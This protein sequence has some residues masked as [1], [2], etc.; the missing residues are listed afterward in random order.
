MY[1]SR[2]LST[3][4]DRSSAQIS[5][6]MLMGPR[7]AGKTTFMRQ[8]NASRSF[9]TLDD[10]ELRTLAR[11]DP[12]TFLARFPPPVLIDEFHYAPQLLPYIKM[13]VDERRTRLEPAGGMYWLTGSQ[14]FQMIK[15]VQES[16]AGRAIIFQL[17]GLS[18]KEI[19]GGGDYAGDFLADPA[20]PFETRKGIR[21]IFH[22]I[23]RGD[24]P[25]L[26]ACPTIDRELYYRSYVQTYIER[27]AMSQIRIRDV[28]LFEKCVRLLASR[29]GQLV[30]LASLAGEVG[31]S[32]PTVKEW[33]TVLERSF[34]IF[35]L[36]PYHG[37]LGQRVLKTPKIYFLDT[38]LACYFL[39]SASEEQIISGAMAGHLFENWVITELIKSYWFKGRPAPLSFWRTKDGAEVDIVYE[40][41]G[42]L[43]P[44]EIKMS[45]SPP[46]GLFTAFERTMSG[47]EPPVGRKKIIC[48]ASMNVP[49]DDHTD[50][51]SALAVE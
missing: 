48:A 16:L 25:E 5:V 46:T 1:I 27:D 21:D 7:Q 35:I 44:V 33:L 50:I 17:L 40:S 2:E 26:W 37:N 39:K 22:C 3:V 41:G 51:V 36:P 9:V 13:I 18:R 6:L 30:N 24:K 47:K 42:L 45:A 20:K 12:K 10:M 34:Q 11:N 19:D 38:G 4:F 8:S 14:Q 23:L 31:V 49:M 28:G 43:H 15:G 32:A 29:I